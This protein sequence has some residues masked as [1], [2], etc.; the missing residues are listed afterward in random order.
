MFNSEPDGYALAEYDAV[1]AVLTA[2]QKGARSA[3]DVTRALSD[4]AFTG[5]AM[6]YRS[7]GKGDLAHSSVIICYDGKSRIPTVVKRYDNVAAG[8]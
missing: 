7:D 6:S 5:V 4:D 8:Q 2:V 3:A 1:T